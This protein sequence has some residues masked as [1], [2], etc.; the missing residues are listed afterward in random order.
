MESG[1]L[2]GGDIIL[3]VNSEPLKDL[4]YQVSAFRVRFNPSLFTFFFFWVLV[5]IDLVLI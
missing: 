3:S 2:R 4:S 5:F 1:L